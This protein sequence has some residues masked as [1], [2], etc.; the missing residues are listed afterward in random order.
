M[1]IEVEVEMDLEMVMAKEKVYILD[2]IRIALA[3]VDKCMITNPSFHV[4]CCIRA[5]IGF[6]CYDDVF[7]CDVDVLLLHIFRRH[8]LRELTRRSRAPIGHSVSK[9][10]P[11][12]PYSVIPLNYIRVH[13]VESAWERRWWWR[14]R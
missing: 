8:T 9:G 2:I 11:C 10:T 3:A 5:Q 13:L 7:N 4:D 14:W 6:V 1:E 12:K